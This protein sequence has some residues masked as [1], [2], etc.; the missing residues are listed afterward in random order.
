MRQVHSFIIGAHTRHQVQNQFAI[1]NSQ[2]ELTKT[3]CMWGFNFLQNHIQI[4][5][6]KIRF[7]ISGR[8]DYVATPDFWRDFHHTSV[9]AATWMANK[10]FFLGF[11]PERSRNSDPVIRNPL[12]G[13]VFPPWSRP[14]SNALPSPSRRRQCRAKSVVLRASNSPFHSPFG[15][16]ADRTR[17]FDSAMQRW[18]WPSVYWKTGFTSWG[19]HPVGRLVGGRRARFNPIFWAGRDGGGTYMGGAPNE[20]EVGQ[21]PSLPGGGCTTP[22]SLL[23]VSRSPDKC[24]RPPVS[25]ISWPPPPHPPLPSPWLF[26]SLTRS[27]A[28][29]GLTAAL[30]D[31]KI[32]A[33][34]H[35]GGLSIVWYQWWWG[36]KLSDDWSNFKIKVVRKMIFNRID[37][38]KLILQLPPSTYCYYLPWRPKVITRNVW[39]LHCSVRRVT[40]SAAFVVISF[41]AHLSYTV[42]SSQP[43]RKVGVISI[44]F[45]II[46][47]WD[48]S[49]L[50]L[51]RWVAL[52]L[53]AL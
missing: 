3:N 37:S 8:I 12:P 51:L 7:N 4:C 9:E 35:D 31:V 27:A 32:A 44:S 20:G 13:F 50:R 2:L 34:I 29:R 18:L 39:T 11:R 30:T 28:G 14:I 25:S 36:E 42:S 21:A 53:S 48:V 16:A 46:S 1:T 19:G 23:Q 52:G 22:F 33:W 40:W 26:P 45:P 5:S 24:N 6:L 47:F 43:S 38:K 41:Y 15:A 17:K 49:E 10:V